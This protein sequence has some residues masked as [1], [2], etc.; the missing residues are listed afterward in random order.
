MN[1][2]SKYF[3]RIRVKRAAGETRQAESGKP[4]CQWKGCDQEGT[5]R[6]P[7][8]RQHDGEYF[9]FCFDHVR[10]YN[11]TYNYFTGLD[12]DQVT[13]FQKDALTGHRPTWKMGANAWAD[14]VEAR[15]HDPLA[16]ISARIRARLASRR[17]GQDGGHQPGP[18]RKP[19]SLELKAL[20]DLG[21][22]LSANPEEIKARYKALV[23]RHHPDANGGDRSSE[24][25]LRNIIQAYKQLKQ[26][27]FC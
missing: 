13:R 26:A 4:V 23:K 22:P 27:G 19:R 16:S 12:D 1:L 10:E 7:K 15:A 9:L 5:H 25:R 3:D 14:N 6:A 20:E 24:D 17:A 21:L 11:K 8:G 2:R 18:T